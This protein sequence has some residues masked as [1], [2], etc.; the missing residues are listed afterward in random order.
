[1]K[2]IHYICRCNILWLVAIAGCGQ[3]WAQNVV[4]T[5]GASA[6]RIGVK[7][8]VQVQ[9]TVK[10]AQDLQSISSPP[11]DNFDV[12]GGPFQS[13]NSSASF[14]GRG[15]VQS[16]SISLTYVLQPK[17]EGTFTIPAATAKDAA[18]HTYQSNAITIQVVPGS[19]M[20]QQQRRPAARDPF[21]DDD[22]LLAMMQRMQQM[23]QA[24]MQQMQQMQQQRQQ[25]MQQQA[26]Q[27]EEE[28][29]VNDEQIKKDL[30]IRVVADKSKVHTGEQVTISYKLYSRLPMQMGISKLPSLNGFWTQDF[31]IPQQAKPTEEVLDGK[32]YQVFLLKKSAIFPQ[33]PGNL[34]LDP[35]E[36]KGVARIV[37]QVKRRMSDL[38]ADPFG[39]GTLMMND[40]FFNNAM[41]STMAYKDVEVH[42]KSTP[43]KISVAPLPENG[44]PEGF[45]GAVGQF[46]INS[47]IDKTELTT[48]DVATITL[49]ITGSGNL[50]LMEAPRPTLPNGLSTFDPQVTDTVTSRT[51]TIS[52]S[53][54][55]T[56]T[57]SS[58]TPGEYTVPSI[59]FSYFNPQTG[60]YKTEH[61]QPIKIHVRPG[62]TYTAGKGS[63]KKDLKD[64]HDIS[65]QPLTSISPSSAP[66]MLT[67][68]YWALYALPIIS[69]LGISFWKRRQEE[70]SRDTVLLRRRRANKVALKRL[71]VAGKLLQQKAS[72]PFYDEVSK[73]IWLYLSDKLNIPLASLS[74]DAATEALQARNVP[75]ALQKSLENVIIDCETALYASGGAQ[76]MEATYNEALKVIGELEDVF[77]A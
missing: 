66:M 21:G 12:V 8:Q 6:T 57:L 19:L 69:L 22:D 49:K 9:Y 24:Q 30:F 54:I 32:K 64:I 53:K 25:Q 40:P 20:Q 59:A 35:A 3:A 26:Q 37:Q 28:P 72:K 15:W 10:D 43:L 60:E 16:E 45:G 2:R 73:A 47:S 62:K 13:R 52:G 75:V 34:E 38:F 71:A 27:P 58:Q 5:A 14:N 65:T 76:K 48:D 29:K 11:G 68:S 42:I 41:Y 33:Q 44:K 55:I 7:D 56:Y 74:R 17:R 36:A 39:G 50:K 4:F 70:L 23:Q 31:E 67:G 63:G 61:T 18:G 51:T 77:K 46:S 1:M